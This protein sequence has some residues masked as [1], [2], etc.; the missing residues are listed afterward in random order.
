LL[1]HSQSFVSQREGE[2]LWRLIYGLARRIAPTGVIF[3]DYQPL[4]S[5][6]GQQLLAKLHACG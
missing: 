3:A 2:G 6:S 5:K 4:G 1:G